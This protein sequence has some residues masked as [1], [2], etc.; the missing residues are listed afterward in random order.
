MTTPP[1]GDAAGIV[2]EAAKVLRAYRYDA[3][4]DL[5][6]AKLAPDRQ[7]RTVVVAGE[8]QRGKSSLINALVGHD[9]LCP[10]GVDVTSTV[11][12][13]V[14]PDP[15]Q[16]EPVTAELFF[17]SGA[18]SVPPAGL[19]DWITTGG[20]R[21]GDPAAD[22]LPTAAAIG[23]REA[24]VAAMT[25]IDTPGV[26]GLDHGLTR[27][28]AQSAQQACVLVLVCD[29]S[30]PMTAPELAFVRDAGASVDAVLVVV[31]KT[32]KN[33]RRWREIVAENTEILRR[34]LGREIPVF[35]V[36][37]LLAVLAETAGTD[38]ERARLTAESGIGALRAEL[39][40]RLDAAADLPGR[41][42][43][44]TCVSGLDAVRDKITRELA[45]L[46]A[47]PDALPD[48]DADLARLTELK[49][50]SRQWEQYLARDLTLLKQSAVDDLDARLDAVRDKWTRYVNTHGMA[51]LRRRAQTF[52]ADMQADLQAAMAATLAQFIQRL[53]DEIVA[54]RFAADPTVWADLSNQLTASLRG[55]RVVNHEVMGKRHGLLD[56]TLL[57][58]GVVG[59]STLGGLVGLSALM[60]VGLAI[61]TVW[62]G[63]NLGFRAIRAGKANLLTWLRETTASTK[64]STAR[65]LEGIIAQAR[66]EIVVHYREYLRTAIDELEQT[67]DDVARTS[68]EDAE[69]RAKKAARLRANLEVVQRRLTA[70]HDYLGGA[71]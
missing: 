48:L 18:R 28:A 30:S 40:R 62:I 2:T 41:D 51:V 26:G 5:A 37:C 22:E 8:V 54:P 32:D 3:V 39:T 65:L 7:L 71:A 55:R 21:A 50:Q 43:V 61:G 27:L 13:S 59:S 66:P 42:A 29:A 6:K 38:D 34:E 45:V 52:T 68:R 10:I 69:A 15:D 57:T 64:T 46:E 12:V 31:T 1:R 49:D 23:L 56:P 36:S 19:A 14:T 4:A 17:P 70:A 16:D 47:G 58:M 11:A 60:G 63:V 24:R 9:G 33:L 53:H 25:L 20:V 44:R 67:I 35:G